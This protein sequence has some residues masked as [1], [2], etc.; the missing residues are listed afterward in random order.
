MLS[1]YCG[2][3]G[4]LDVNSNRL[5]MEA[6]LANPVPQLPEVLRLTWLVARLGM[7]SA[8]S[9]GTEDSHGDPWVP[10]FTIA[11]SC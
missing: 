3:D 7:V 6:V 2:G 1:P 8:L 5:W 11:A 4:E 9:A 10:A